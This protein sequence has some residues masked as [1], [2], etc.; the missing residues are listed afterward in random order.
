MEAKAVADALGMPTPTPGRPTL[1]RNNKYSIELHLIGV[2]A[3]RL[4]DR[5]SAPVSGVILAGLAGALD[6]TL[7]VGE[8]VIDDHDMPLPPGLPFRRG[9][10]H[11]SDCLIASPQ[12]KAALYA[13]TGALAV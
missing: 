3:K 9:P 11:T 10:I 4:P 13:Q 2:G 8:V 7:A 1:C 6:P 5:L 12:E